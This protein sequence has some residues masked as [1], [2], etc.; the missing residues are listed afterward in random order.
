MMNALATLT[1]LC[2]AKKGTKYKRFIPTTDSTSV[3]CSVVWVWTL[4]L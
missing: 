1:M 4:E 3:D 2:Y